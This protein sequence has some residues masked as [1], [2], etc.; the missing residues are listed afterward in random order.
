MTF[1][2]LLWVMIIGAIAWY[3]YH[4]DHPKPFTLPA[5]WTVT[6]HQPTCPVPPKT[7]DWKALK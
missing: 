5:G 4:V 1:S 7:V 3:G 2:N 6:V